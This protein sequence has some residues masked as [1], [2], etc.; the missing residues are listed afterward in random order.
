MLVIP[1]IDLK[2]G[3]CVRLKQGRMTEATV[4][5]EN[6]IDCARHWHRMGAKRLHIVD[7]DGAFSGQMDNI[8]T[9]K[10]LRKEFP[11]MEIQAGGGIRTKD[12]IHTYLEEIKVD[13]IVIG[14]YAIK[15]PSTIHQLTQQ[16]PDTIYLGLDIAANKAHLAGWLET[17]SLTIKEILA[18]FVN[19]SLA[20]IVIT[21]IMNDGML[22]GIDTEFVDQFIGQ[23]SFPLIVAGGVRNIDDIHKL[24]KTPGVE[25]VICGKSLYEGSL[26]FKEALKIAANQSPKHSSKTLSQ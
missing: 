3:K 14:T 24:N 26:D 25:G 4:Y 7:L 5:Y 12:A 20:G 22:S 17:S 23:T 18:Q 13:F 19:T 8:A 6:P 9:I 21:D 1:A 2:Q 11:L 10:K 15:N 16:Y